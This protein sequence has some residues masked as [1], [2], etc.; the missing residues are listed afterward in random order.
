MVGNWYPK[1]PRL[2]QK[3]V[4][5]DSPDGTGKTNIANGLSK[6]IGVP[7]FRMDTQHDNWRKK[8]FQEALEF[9]QTYIASF[10]RQTHGNV[11]MDR[12]YPSEWVY[13]KVFKRETNEQVLER[14]DRE[15]AQ[16]GAYII[17]PLRRD[18]ANNR[19]DEVVPKEKLQAL[20]D[21]YLAFCQWSRCTT[22]KIFVDDF[23][24]DL[25][26]ELAAIVPEF[27]FDRDPDMLFLKDVVLAKPVAKKD[28]TNLFDPIE[29]N[30]S[31]TNS[32]KAKR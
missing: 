18:Y 13:S 9:D 28:V 14:V 1:R 29:P 2:T 5:F 30:H 3:I 12:A 31:Y 4:I 19:E 6:K 15:F 10:L 22:I 11:I 8:R 26:K 32:F 27:D 16:M 23:S 20:H 24:D 7:Y 25:E 21:T 17:V